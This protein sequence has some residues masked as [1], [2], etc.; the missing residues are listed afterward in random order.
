MLKIE[1]VSLGFDNKP[2]FEPLSLTISGGEMALLMAPS[3]AGKSTLLNWICGTPSPH[4]TSRGSITLNGR[5]VDAL[6][7][8][9]RRIGI[10]FQ[11]PLMFPHLTV[12]ENLSF[13]L[14]AMGG[15]S[16]RAA[17]IDEQ[18]AKVGM[19]GMALRDPLTL[20]GGQKARVALLRSLLARPDALLLDEPF[21]SLDGDTRA[22][23]AKLV[24]DEV[25]SRGLPTL[26]VSHDPRDHHYA[27]GTAVHLKPFKTP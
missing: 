4:L 11:E 25:T 1:N 23:F 15:K 27:D 9:K 10:M 12:G 2:L 14:V 20:S 24:K 6:P 17:I 19:A 18:L 16:E 26:M 3:G 5:L 22:D 13:G 7:T 21:S 8:E